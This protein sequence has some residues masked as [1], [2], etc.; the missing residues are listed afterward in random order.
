MYKHISPEYWI[1]DG[2]G[3]KKDKIKVVEG[4]SSNEGNA[5]TGQ[6][7]FNIVAHIQYFQTNMYY[8]A[9]PFP[10]G[11]LGGAGSRKRDV[12]VEVEMDMG[13]G[14]GMVEGEG[15]GA[16]GVQVEEKRGVGGDV[17]EVGLS[18]VQRGVE[19]MERARARARG[20]GGVKGDMGEEGNE[21]EGEGN[22]ILEK[23]SLPGMTSGGKTGNPAVFEERDLQR[24]SRWDVETR[25][26]DLLAM[27]L[28]Q[29]VLTEFVDLG[30]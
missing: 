4:L 25:V 13:E 12:G 14:A 6:L 19:R 17:D 2:L 21:G 5:G 26:E 29:G 30:L 27:G 16:M 3:N 10:L 15:K 18:S 20:R 9:M 7:K 1:S 28:G 23:R 11:V 24:S 8:C 22:R